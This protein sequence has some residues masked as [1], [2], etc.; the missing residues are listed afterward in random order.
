MLIACWSYVRPEL[1]SN[2]VIISHE[3]CFGVDLTPTLRYIATT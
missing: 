3:D 2:V 1:G